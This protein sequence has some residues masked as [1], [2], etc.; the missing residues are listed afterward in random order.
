MDACTIV[1]VLDID[2]GLNLMLDMGSTRGKHVMV[3]EMS[4]FRLLSAIRILE[5]LQTS[6]NPPVQ[7]VA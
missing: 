1:L 5:V 3:M 7:I 4:E 2:M 6:R